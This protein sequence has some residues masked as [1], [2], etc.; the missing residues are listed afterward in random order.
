MLRKVAPR[1]IG[2]RQPLSNFKG[3]NDAADDTQ[4]SPFEIANS[5]IGAHTRGSGTDPIT[6][7]S[8]LAAVR[9]D[10]LNLKNLGAEAQAKAQ[11]GSEL[12]FET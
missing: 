2:L 7:S 4:L 6:I 1:S 11:I 3:V 10:E 9:S 8:F 12:E 5:R